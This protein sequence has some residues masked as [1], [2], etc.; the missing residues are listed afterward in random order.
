MVNIVGECLWLPILGKTSYLYKSNRAGK[1]CPYGVIDIHCTISKFKVMTINPY[2]RLI[3]LASLFFLL[4]LGVIS[5]TTLLASSN[6]DL[7]QTMVLVNKTAAER[8]NYYNEARNSLNGQIQISKNNDSLQNVNPDA[9]I[10]IRDIQASSTISQN[11]AGGITS[12]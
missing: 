12:R 8:N 1:P 10:K 5:Y 7:E 6:V 3:L 11:T 4:F 2:I 9:M